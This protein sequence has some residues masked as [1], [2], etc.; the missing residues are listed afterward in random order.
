MNESANPET[1][2]PSFT[3]RGFIKTTTAAA[4]GV[5][6]APLFARSSHAAGGGSAMAIVLDVNDAV[7]KEP[8]ARWAAEQLLGALN[9]RGAQAAIYESL[10]QVP[11]GAE[12]IFAT[13]RDSSSARQSF[14]AA[15]VPDAP[16]ALGFARG[17]IGTHKALVACGS[18]T[19]GLVYALLELADRVKLGGE[20]AATLRAVNP[21]VEKPAN[22]MRSVG[23]LFTSDVEDKPWYNDRDFWQDYLSVLVAQRFNRFHLVFGLAYDFTREIRDCYFHFAYPFLLPVPGYNVRAVPLSDAERDSNLEMLRFISGQ[24]AL[25]GLRFQ[26]GL[27]THA[28]KWTNSPQANYNTEG[29]T[30]QTQAAY[31]RDA[32]KTLLQACPLIDGVAI[33]IHGESGVAEG[34]YDFWKTVFDGIVNSGRRVD[35]EL[36]AKGL[37]QKLLDIALATGAPVSVCPKFWAEH[38]GLPYPQAAI[39]PLEMP[40]TNAQSSFL[41]LSTGSRNH[42]R[43]GYADFLTEDRK[44]TVVHRIWPGTQRVLLWGDPEMAAAYS[45]ESAFCGS[46]GFELFEPM[47]FK[48]RKGSGRPGG[49][50]AYA[51][52]SLSTG[53]R[54][55]EKYLYSYRLWGRLGYNPNEKPETWRRLLRQQVG[56]SAEA[57]EAALASS[58][59]ILPLITTAHCPSAAN[60][61]YW[62]EIY[63]NMPMVNLAPAQP[64]SDTPSPHRF[65]T[66]STLDPELFAGIDEFAAELLAGSRSGK[67][68]PAEVAQWLQNFSQNSTRHL[69]A[70]TAKSASS[71]SADFRR[72]D[73]DV[74]IQNGLGLFFAW[75]FRAG[76]LY[77][78]YVQSGHRP[79]LEQALSAYRLARKSWAD[80]AERA[81]GIYVPDVTYGYSGESRGH[82]L[83]RLAAIDADIADMQAKSAETPGGA[84]FPG[85]DVKAL[86]RAVA[87]V[88]A[89]STRPAFHVTHT[90]VTHFKRGE[91]VAVQVTAKGKIDFVELRYRRVDQAEL[92][93]AAGM[94]SQGAS[95]T[96]TIP[97]DYTDSAFPLQ[98]YFVLRGGTATPAL[99]PGLGA[100]LM[101]QP[102]YVIRQA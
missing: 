18:D 74:A 31:C 52:A 47:S 30:D 17:K 49:R 25:R 90:P 9:A 98:Y 22:S 57:A 55:Y 54:D 66:V 81:R 61:N 11:A 102:Y 7:A 1:V 28:Y 21:S 12:C 15:G 3:R 20:P 71:A 27:W 79:A 6:T 44:Y 2:P 73:T 42:T 91:S 19:R 48:G 78:L 80:L 72:L 68:S 50:Q 46:D 69:A 53:V 92:W 32:L 88:L 36:H 56:G 77:A 41:A 39:R 5:A 40:T 101:D 33:R 75:K 24:C 89:P 26:L 34:S 94:K 100:S 87:E 13:G 85:L 84:G 29:L 76:V 45:R 99:H 82:W 38:M 4:A 63:L 96:A 8:P 67:Y 43:Y 58:S 70:T 83:D 60:N 62:P 16:E 64:Y 14:P 59:R 95:W 23:R 86:E 51:D 10:D 35:L 37:D 93:R 97:G 65:G